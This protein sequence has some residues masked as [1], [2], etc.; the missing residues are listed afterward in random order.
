L[1]QHTGGGR[2]L[3][4]TAE[5]KKFEICGKIDIFK[6]EFDFDIKSFM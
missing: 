2:P 4:R 5:E 1:Y 3:P 6:K